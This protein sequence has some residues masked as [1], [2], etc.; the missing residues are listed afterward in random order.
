MTSATVVLAPAGTEADAAVVRPPCLEPG[1]GAVDGP[2]K[3]TGEATDASRVSRTGHSRDQVERI[4]A[5]VMSRAQASASSPTSPPGPKT[6][7][8][9]RGSVTLPSPPRAPKG[10]G[11]V[12]RPHLCRAEAPVETGAGLRR[13]IARDA[14][15]VSLEG[16]EEGIDRLDV[17]SVVAL[18]LEHGGVR[19][20]IA[21]DVHDARQQWGRGVALDE[22]DRARDARQITQRARGAVEPFAPP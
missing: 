2:V 13:T 18:E 19:Q 9:W 4:L 17:T 15:E 21:E 7:G 14:I 16:L 8:M 11:H 10:R 1:V 12:E 22:Q 20:A 6:S 5:G 3:C